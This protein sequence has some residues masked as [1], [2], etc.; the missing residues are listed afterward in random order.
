MKLPNLLPRDARVVEICSALALLLA[1]LSILL[2]GGLSEVMRQVRPG[3]FWGAF[4]LYIGAVQ[5]WV[6][7]WH[8]KFELT[9][10]AAAFI[11]GT[12]WVWMSMSGLLTHNHADDWGALFIGVGNLYSFMIGFLYQRA[13]WLK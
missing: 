5:F 12:F 6:L 13:K 11:A 4:L 8:P 2:G 3:Q 10:I 7:W 9:R 1:G